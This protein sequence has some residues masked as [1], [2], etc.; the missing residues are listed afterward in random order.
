MSGK[1]MVVA[2]AALINDA[3][4]V[5]LGQRLPGK[6]YA[7]LWEF[8]GGKVEPNETPEQALAREL[9]EELG[10][11][12]QAH[13]M[14]PITFASHTH[15]TGRHVLMPLF[16]LRQWQGQIEPREGQ[17]LTWIAPQ[18]IESSSLRLVPHDDALLPALRRFVDGG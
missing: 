14:C 9:S 15:G 11:V 7:G 1:L 16:G 4:F 8:P 13:H 10:I 18:A 2:A 5:L 17:G 6:D 3:G 12:T